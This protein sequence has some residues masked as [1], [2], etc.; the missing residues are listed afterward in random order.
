MNTKTKALVSGS[1][2]ALLLATTL[3]VYASGSDPDP[4]Q[5]T[6]DLDA[7]Q[8]VALGE[9]PGAVAESELEEEDGKVVWEFEIVVADGT[10]MEV[11]IDA[12]TGELISSEPED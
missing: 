3:S 2:T 11:L 5:V 4:S 8:L 7:A 10:R 9:F 12:N 1:F 6:F